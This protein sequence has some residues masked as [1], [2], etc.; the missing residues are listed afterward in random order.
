M[1]GGRN[2]PL[3]IDLSGFAG[4]EMQVELRFVPLAGETRIVWEG[5]E[6]E[7]APDKVAP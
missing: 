2:Q 1:P 3:T 6:F 4:R 7:L 5:A